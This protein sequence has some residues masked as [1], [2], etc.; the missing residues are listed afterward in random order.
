VLHEFKL[1]LDDI[2]SSTSDSG[3]DVKR[4]LSVAV[5]DK[6]WGWCLPHLANCALKEAFGTTLS[7]AATKN[8]AVRAL[9]SKLKGVIEHLNKS[10]TMKVRCRTQP[11]WYGCD[12]VVAH[13]HANVHIT[14]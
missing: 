12:C 2:F 10:S 14:V 3:S 9:W 5:G 1:S 8:P 4:L 11:A 13:G 7:A 6:H